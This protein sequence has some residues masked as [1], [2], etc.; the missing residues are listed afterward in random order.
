L[1]PSR[2]PVIGTLL[3]SERA[4]RLAASGLDY[5]LASMAACISS[6]V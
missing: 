6:T 2:S 5:L 3:R 1:P 4:R